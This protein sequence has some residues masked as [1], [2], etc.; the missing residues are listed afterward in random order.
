VPSSSTID[1]ST[2]PPRVELPRDYD[3]AVDLLER[4]VIEGRGDR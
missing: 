4:N 1:L 2:S 3:V